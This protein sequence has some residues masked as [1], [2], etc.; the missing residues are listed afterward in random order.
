[1]KAKRNKK[2][3]TIKNISRTMG[4]YTTILNKSLIKGK[5]FEKGNRKLK[6]FQEK[7]KWR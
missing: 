2:K 4:T 6:E 7:L 1:M 3:K 5:L